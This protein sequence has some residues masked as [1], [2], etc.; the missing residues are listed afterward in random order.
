[1]IR[2][3]NFIYKK[4]KTSELFKWKRNQVRITPKADV[5]L[6]VFTIYDPTKEA[7]ESDDHNPVEKTAEVTPASNGPSRTF[8]TPITVNTSRTASFLNNMRKNMIGFQKT[9][10]QNGDS[11]SVHKAVGPL[12]WLVIIIAVFSFTVWLTDNDS[13]IGS[14]Y[15]FSVVADCLFLV[16][17]IYC[18]LNNKN[19]AS[20]VGLRFIQ[21][22]ARF[23]IF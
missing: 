23:Y 1:M 4:L 22:K 10:G 20:F 3:S 12:A 9:C 8:D 18:Y 16:V 21:F 6:D 7:N 5:V 11:S 17:P 15:L 14:I 13:S 2:G 19:I